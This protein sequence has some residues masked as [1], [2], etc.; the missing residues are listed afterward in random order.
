MLGLKSTSISTKKAINNIVWLFGEKVLT[1]VLALAISVILARYLEVS[2]FGKFN[3]L[4]SV[5]LILM[6]FSALGLNAI[7]VRELVNSKKESNVIVGTA[8]ILRVA[9]GIIST[10]LVVAL[11]QLLD[12]EL[13][14]PEQWIVLGAIG[15]SFSSLYIVDF[16]FQSI[17]KSKYVVQVRVVVLIVSSFAKLVGVYYNVKL[18]YFL[19]VIVF[20][21]IITGGLLCLYF[22]WFKKWSFKLKFEFSYAK[23]LLSQSK[24]L[25]L[26]GVMSIVCLK[27]DQIMIGEMLNGEELGIYSVAVRLSEVWYFFPTAIVASFFPKLLNSRSDS[28]L[29]EKNLQQL[30]DYLFWLG[31][32]LALVITMLSSLII[33]VL[34]GDNYTASS[35]ILNIHIWSG[36]FIFIRALL[37]KWLIAEGLLSF[38]L[39]S[40]GAAAV[41]NILLNYFL[42]PSFG[43]TGAAWATLISYAIS[44]YLILWFHCKTR[45]M[46]EIM[47][48]TT[49]F[50]YRVLKKKL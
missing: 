27:I 15:S 30:C 26:S 20:E 5:I 35:E 13:L 28:I 7:I 48:K 45:P 36:V 37:S 3:Y 6:P 22:I 43:I 34:Y 19:W 31:I 46:A 40:H 14:I 24:W 21:P 11:I 18:E 38:S 50:P 10:L 17:V 12:V 1:M 42:I 33:K 32:T 49:T 4:L 8:L 2:D 41:M 16:Y 23:E 25:I 9:G 47:T 29:Y 44:G 39:V